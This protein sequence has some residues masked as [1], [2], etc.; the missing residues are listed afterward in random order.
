[1]DRDACEDVYQEVF[2]IFVRRMG[3]I[4]RST[5]LPKWFITTTHRVCHQWF[6]QAQ[7][8][9]AEQTHPI[10]DPV[11]APDLLLEWERQHVVRQALR[12]LGGRCEELLVAL[13]T[14]QGPEAYEDVA[15]RLGIPEGSIGPTRARCL[16][17]LTK[18]M[19]SLEREATR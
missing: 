3:T 12:R 1:M 4:R 15:R 8:S 17:K 6:K 19:E 9:R 16:G 11:P 13:Y 2:S 10:D 14:D 18:I 5:A 7:R